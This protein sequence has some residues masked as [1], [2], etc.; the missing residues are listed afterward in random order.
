MAFIPMEYPS[1]SEKAHIDIAERVMVRAEEEHHVRMKD[2]RI[3]FLIDNLYRE[4]LATY[5][6]K[7]P[8]QVIEFSSLEKYSVTKYD[9][10]HGEKDGNITPAH[11]F[12]ERFKLLVKNDDATEENEDL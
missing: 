2:P 10:E 12:G 8:D 7:H 3:V 1:N 11:E 6:G 9:S 5:L 4:E